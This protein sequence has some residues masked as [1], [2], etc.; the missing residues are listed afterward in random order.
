M[1]PFHCNNGHFYIANRYIYANDNKNLRIVA[2][3]WQKKKWLG[4]CVT[5]VHLLILVEEKWLACSYSGMKQSSRKMF[6]ECNHRHWASPDSV[7][8]IVTKSL[9]GGN[10][11]QLE[12]SQKLHLSEGSRSFLEPTKPTAPWPGE[13]ILRGKTAEAWSST[14]AYNSPEVKN[15]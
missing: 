5:S 11:V 1:L 14:L 2:F 3:P 6:M 7:A 13:T 9:D 15:E 12:A 8:G 10:V 4:E